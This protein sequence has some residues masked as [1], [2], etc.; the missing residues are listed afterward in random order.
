MCQRHYRMQKR[1]R[2]ASMQRRREARRAA[3]LCVW[4]PGDRPAPAT[5]GSTSCLACRIA[6]RRVR[7]D[8]E[9]VKPDVSPRADRIAA[10]TGKDK[11]GRTRYRGQ[12]RRGQQTHAAL[13]AQDVVM[14]VESFDAFR[15]GVAI[16]GSAEAEVMHRAERE[17]VKAET[18][19]QGERVGRHIDDVLERL[20]HFRQRH[21]PRDGEK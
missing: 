11:D 7:E 19:N 12:P 8:D 10:R 15:A 14:A 18:A 3:G 4:C 20:G 2:N 17:R 1:F 16:L 5:E 13:N 9:G 21:G 6:R